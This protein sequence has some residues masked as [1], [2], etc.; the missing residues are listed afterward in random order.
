MTARPERCSDAARARCDPLAG[1]ASHVRGWLVLED[2][3]PWGRD[4]W[5]DARLPEGLGRELLDRARRAGVRPLLARRPT[6]RDGSRVP[7]ARRAFAAFS[8]PGRAALVTT[9]LADPAAVLD[10][11]L[12]GLAGGRL[13]DWEPMAEPFLG[14]CTHGRHDACCAIRGRPVAQALAAV[15]PEATWEVSHLGG[16]RFAANLLALPAGLYFG[17][18]GPDTVAG[19][20][21]TFRAGAIDPAHFRGRSGWPMSVQVAESALR[22]HLSYAARRGIHLRG[23]ERRGDTRVVTFELEGRA[24][25]VAVHREE[26]P[27]AL[28]T[29]SATRPQPPRVWVAHG[30][31][32]L[33]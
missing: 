30:V 2:P 27:P 19:V 4:A 5:L 15:E 3:G 24:W 31:V 26:A 11:D 10:V 32:P 21:A 23:S 7:R 8:R 12:E 9:V 18:L 6:D 14:V 22:A 20:V 13:P 33:D 29:C 28:L 17:G 1:T 25:R 16:D